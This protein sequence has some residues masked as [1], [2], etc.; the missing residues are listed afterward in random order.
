MPGGMT[1]FF[2]QLQRRNVFKVGAS[3][4]VGA[5]IALQA[6][7]ILLP[8]F[9]A[10]DWVMRLVAALLILALPV[11]LVLAWVFEVTPAGIRRTTDVPEEQ[12]IRGDTSRRLNYVLAGLLG[13]ALI[14]IAVD[15]LWLDGAQA[16]QLAGAAPSI[17]GSGDVAAPTEP[18]VLPNS[19]AVLPLDNLTTNP[20]NEYVAAGLHEEIL[21]QL[22]K[23]KNVSVIART[24]VLPYGANRP[25]I[26]E[27]ARALNVQSVME[28]TVRYSGSRIR[29]TTQLIDAAA[30]T[31]LWSETYDRE[32]GDVFAI[33]SDIAMSVANALKAEFS[34][35]ERRAISKEP[36]VSDVAY[37]LYLRAR[38]GSPNAH[39]LL[40]E[41]VRLD[42]RFALALGF[43]AR[44]YAEAIINSTGGSAQNDWRSLAQLAVSNAERALSIDP[45]IGIAH[46]A[47]GLIHQRLWRW[48]DA[49]DAFRRALTFSPN[50]TQVI[51][52][53]AWHAAFR[54]D[55]AESARLARRRVELSPGL[56]AAHMDLGIALE[57]AGD[58]DGAL[59]SHRAALAITR[60]WTISRQHAGLLEARK[61]NAAAARTDFD[62]L[63]NQFGGNVAIVF[64]PELAVGYGSI[65]RAE[66][67][68]RFADQIFALAKDRE[69]GAGTLAMAY[70]AIGDAD[71]AAAQLELAAER[72]EKGEPDQGFF[73]L[74]HIKSNWFGHP[75]LDE[76]RF[77]A[78]RARLWPGEVARR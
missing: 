38:T 50:D 25:P 60:T 26:P 20:D 11:V 53:Y 44:L 5:W 46:D 57:Y 52:D 75:V 70:L 51:R 59:D 64:L 34:E 55:H 68:K 72:V 32:F 33:E 9:D 47:L 15:Q 29:V 74:M 6:A 18:Q 43:K 8:T 40:D 14:F 35:E 76:P 37:T 16:P 49:G 28:G 71:G 63:A 78:L 30:G 23:L 62:Y 19:V 10:P 2:D 65:G 41:A 67:A 54:G 58:F 61:G 45:T 7:G 56:A 39:A 27:I 48:D 21:N 4:A 31:Q 1:V 77:V 36:T 17:G 66:D 22:A 3:Y 69:I 12:S 24:S 73:S 42:P 13:A